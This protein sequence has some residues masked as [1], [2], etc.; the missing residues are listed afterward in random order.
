MARKK[1]TFEEMMNEAFTQVKK[2]EIK[3]EEKVFSIDNLLNK[4][5]QDITNNAMKIE[6]I[7]FDKLVNS[8][9]DDFSKDLV[10]DLR[11]SIEE[12][13]L[14][15]PLTVYKNTEDNYVVVSGNTRLMALKEI[16]KEDN[17]LFAYV[18]VIIIDKPKNDTEER[19]YISIY[20]Q[21][22][23]KSVKDKF[24]DFK[25][26]S[27]YFDLYNQDNNFTKK[28]KTDFLCSK[29]G[30]SREIIRRYKIILEK[31]TDTLQNLCKQEVISIKDASD[32]AK[33]LPVEQ[34]KILININDNNITNEINKYSPNNAIKNEVKNEIKKV[35]TKKEKKKEKKLN[36]IKIKMK[37]IKN[38]I[39]L[40]VIEKGEKDII[41]YL[42]NA[43]IKE[44][45]QHE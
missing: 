13:G 38:Y 34:E 7:Q 22:R 11:I 30:V 16:R 40:D 23:E 3:P 12:S 43:L 4:E 33:L 18:P 1:K 5:S 24:I 20:N 2:E 32:I 41:N 6:F 26:Y 8:K 45:K 31:G 29:M 36:I 15:T 39:P 37:D 35:I 19:Y 42:I 28:E 17:T 10:E 9:L 21:Q 44:D 25:A 14:K 27:D